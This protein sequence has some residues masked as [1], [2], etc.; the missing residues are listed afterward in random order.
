MLDQLPAHHARVV[1]LT[2]PSLLQVRATPPDVTVKRDHLAYIL[3]TS[4]STGRP[5]AVQIPQRA[6]LNFV[7][8]MRAVLTLTADDVVLAIA[9]LAFDIAVL[10]LLVPLITGSRI[11][12]V[13]RAVAAD[14]TLLREHLARKHI[15]LLQGTPAT[16][17]LL[18][19]SGWHPSAGLKMLSGGEAMPPQLAKALSGFGATLWNAYGPTE[20]TVYSTAQTITADTDRIT[21]G[22]P[23]ANNRCYILDK[24]GQPVPIGAV[25]ELYIGGDALARGY[26]FQPDLTAVRFV[27]DPFSNIPGNR[28]YQSG[29]MGRYLPDGRLEFQG[30]TDFQVKIRGFRIELAE[31]EATLTLHDAVKQASVLDEIDANGNQR[32]VAYVVPETDALNSRAQVLEQTQISGWNAVYEQAFDENAEGGKRDDFLSWNSSYTGLPIPN[33]E[34]R[35]WLGNTIQRI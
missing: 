33:E 5:K 22:R 6:L 25:G 17:W 11:E 26:R 9:S 13:D 14:G 27:P 2:D 3:F 18:L 30:R 28:L 1:D 15:T 32:L 31:I 7:E 34:M 8:A 35:D 21:I 10:E 24:F 23:L 16:W 29:D 20:T 19:D 12:I 4:G